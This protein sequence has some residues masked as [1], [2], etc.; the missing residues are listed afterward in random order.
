[1]QPVRCLEKSVAAA[2]DPQS[3]RVWTYLALVAVDQHGVHCLIV[4]DLKGVG[5]ALERD[6]DRLGLMRWDGNLEMLNIVLFHEGDVLGWVILRDK[7]AVGVVSRGRPKC[8][9]KGS[10]GGKQAYRMVLK[11]RE[12]RCSKLPCIGKLLL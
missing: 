3:S 1:M 12:R 10:S 2:S 8:E 7:R 4:E 9:G 6:G 5:D 11:P